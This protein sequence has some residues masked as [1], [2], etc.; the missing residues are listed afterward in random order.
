MTH[1]SRHWATSA[2]DLAIAAFRVVIGFLFF[3]H[4]ATSLWAWPA[5]PYGGQT[6]QLGAWPGWWGAAIQVAC[7]ALLMVG[8]GTRAAAFLG[9]GSMAYA[10]FWG[11]QADGAL[12]I[13]ND[14][15][16]AALFCWAMFVLV[17]IGGGS[18]ALD[19]VVRRGRGAAGPDPRVDS[20]AV[21]APT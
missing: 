5:E 3:C 19:R 21:G 1:T 10:Y 2:S 7:G 12:P 20:R 16:P 6:A 17:F 18:F 15:E 13:Q 9:S 8:L 11:H 14:G 4:G